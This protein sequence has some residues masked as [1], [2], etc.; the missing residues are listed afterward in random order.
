MIIRT[1]QPKLIR[2]FLDWFSL[3]LRFNRVCLNFKA[4]KL[5]AAVQIAHE[6]KSSKRES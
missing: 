2:L 3:I 1:N 6:Q 4:K 5:I